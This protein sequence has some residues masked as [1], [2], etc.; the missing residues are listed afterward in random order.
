[1]PFFLVRCCGTSQ[2][3]LAKLGETSAFL[4]SDLKQC[5]LEFCGNSDSNCL[6]FSHGRYRILRQTIDLHKS[7]A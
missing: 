5:L 4:H 2:Q 3:N 1:M 6:V 7:F